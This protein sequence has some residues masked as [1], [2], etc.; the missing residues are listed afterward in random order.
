MNSSM[1]KPFL[2]ACLLVLAVGFAFGEVSG[3]RLL[4]PIRFVPPTAVAVAKLNW[5][6]VRQDDRFR[7]M[8]NADQ[9]ARS[10]AQLNISGNDVSEII[11]FSGMNSSPTGFLGGIF[12]GTYSVPAVAAKLRS[13]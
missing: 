4:V 8:L 1:I 3:Q 11:I 13:Q 12:R 5:T 6:V 10:L 7:A 9:L 2:C